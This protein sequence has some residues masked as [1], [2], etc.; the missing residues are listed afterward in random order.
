MLKLKY[1]FLITLL[2]IFPVLTLAHSG[3]TDSVGCHTCRT[4]CYSWGLSSG[5]YHCHRS[6]GYIQPKE[7]VTSHKNKYGA[8]YTE[9]TS[10]YKIPKKKTTNYNK[11]NQQQIDYGTSEKIIDTMNQ[12]FNDSTS[13]ERKI[14]INEKKS[15]NNDWFWW[16]I[17]GGSGGIFIK[18]KINNKK[19]KK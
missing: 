5:E 12:N 2:A 1:L 18:N 14:I 10:K 7:Q 4:N 9:P 8:G 17:I 15:N 3:R 19:N 11:Q 13:K 16:L 6:K